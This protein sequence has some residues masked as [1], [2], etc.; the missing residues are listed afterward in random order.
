MQKHYTAARSLC[1]TPVN[2]PLMQAPPPNTQQAERDA[3]VI[4][5]P[6][7]DA[8]GHVDRDRGGDQHAARPKVCDAGPELNHTLHINAALFKLRGSVV[9]SAW[10][11]VFVGEA[12]VQQPVVLLGC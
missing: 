5:A 3:L 12:T 8:P 4:L 11:A 10:W 1:Q 9:G 2:Q 6:C 7:D